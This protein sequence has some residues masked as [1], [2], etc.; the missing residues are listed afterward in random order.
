LPE[1]AGQELKMIEVRLKVHGR[2]TAQV[3]DVLPT[4]IRVLSDGRLDADGYVELAF[5]QADVVRRRPVGPE[6]R[7]AKLKADA[8]FSWQL[9]AGHWQAL[10]RVLGIRTRALRRLAYRPATSW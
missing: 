9:Q 6:H 3:L 1:Y 5:R 2:R 7:I 8:N 4:R 10:S